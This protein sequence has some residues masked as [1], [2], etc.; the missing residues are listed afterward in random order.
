MAEDVRGALAEALEL[1]A[2]CDHAGAAALCKRASLMPS[3]DPRARCDALVAHARNVVRGSSPGSRGLAPALASLDSAAALASSATDRARVVAAKA[4][5]LALWAPRSFSADSSAAAISAERMCPALPEAL[6]ASGEAALASGDPSRAETQLARAVASAGA[7]ISGENL[8]EWLSALAIARAATGVVEP[9]RAC[10]DRASQ[11]LAGAS[12]ADPCVSRLH[13]VAVGAVRLASGDARAAL[14]ALQA[15]VTDAVEREAKSDAAR[16]GI[17]VAAAHALAGPVATGRR[18]LKAA[19]HLLGASGPDSDEDCVL[20][21]AARAAAKLQ[22]HDSALSLVSRALKAA[23]RTGGRARRACALAL[24]AQLLARLGR[25]EA[26]GKALALAA[27]ACEADARALSEAPADAAAAMYDCAKAALLLGDPARAIATASKC[28]SFA[29]D[30]RLVLLSCRAKILWGRAA[31]EMMRLEEAVQALESAL[32]EA[33]AAKLLPLEARALCWLSLARS[34]VGTEEP[35]D[36]WLTRALETAKARAGARY[37]LTSGGEQACSKRLEASVLAKMGA[38]SVSSGDLTSGL[39]SFRQAADRFAA[40][41]LPRSLARVRLRWAE[42]LA[43]LEQWDSAVQVATPATTDTDCDPILCALWRVIALCHSAAERT[44]ESSKALASAMHIARGMNDQSEGARCLA[45]LRSRRGQHD[46]ALATLDRALSACRKAKNRALQQSIVE[47]MSS[48]M[49][50]VEA[51]R[52]EAVAQELERGHL[53]ARDA[54]GALLVRAVLCQAVCAGDRQRALRMC[55]DCLCRFRDGMDDGVKADVLS[56]LGAVLLDCG[57]LATACDVFEEAAGIYESLGELRGSALCKAGRGRA[58]GAQG[59]EQAAVDALQ[60]AREDA[61]RSGSTRVILAVADALQSIAQAD[62]PTLFAECAVVA[63]RCGDAEAELRNLDSLGALLS[64]EEDGERAVQVHQRAAQ[65]AEALG[66][67][68]LLGHHSLLL[69]EALRHA[70]A[71]KD[72]V[73][74]YKRAVSS[75]RAVDMPQLVSLATYKLAKAYFTQGNGD[76]SMEICNGGLRVVPKGDALEAKYWMLLGRIMLARRNL[77]G[78]FGFLRK[79][80]AAAQASGSPTTESKCNLAVS[81]GKLL[82]GALAESLAHA[83]TALELSRADQ[84]H[85]LSAQVLAV[86]AGIRRMQEDHA[87]EALML[88]EAIEECRAAGDGGALE[89]DLLLALGAAHR[90]AGDWDKSLRAYTASVAI[91][92]ARDDPRLRLDA[93]RGQANVLERRGDIAEALQA[94]QEAVGYAQ[95]C[96]EASSEPAAHARWELAQTLSRAGRRAEAIRHLRQILQD[97]WWWHEAATHCALGKE[98]L[99]LGETH[100]SLRDYQ[101]ALTIYDRHEHKLGRG[102]VLSS[103]A[104]IYLVRGDEPSK[105][106]ATA[107]QCLA[108]AVGCGD[109][110]LE[111]AAMCTLGRAHLARGD[112]DVAGK[113]LVSAWRMCRDACDRPRLAWCTEYIGEVLA[114]RGCFADARQRFDE[115]AKLAAEAGMQR[116]VCQARHNLGC[117]LAQE[118]SYPEASAVLNEALEMAQ[119][120]CDRVTEAAILADMSAVLWATG[121]AGPAVDMQQRALQLVEQP[122]GDGS[123][124]APA[125]TCSVLASQVL[126][127]KGFALLATGDVQLGVETLRA[128]TEAAPTTGITEPAQLLEMYAALGLGCS[129]L[130]KR[131]QALRYYE[132]AEEIASSFPDATRAMQSVLNEAIGEEHALQGRAAQA[133]AR[134]NRA[135]ATAPDVPCR[136]KIFNSTAEAHIESGNFSACAEVAQSALTLAKAAGDPAVC[137]RSLINIGKAL[138]AQRKLRNALQKFAAAMRLSSENGLVF[139]DAYARFSVGETLCAAGE[140]GLAI[141]YL[142]ASVQASRDGGYVLVQ[143][144]ALSALGAAY[145][146]TQ[147]PA[148]AVECLQAALALLEKR[149]HSAEVRSRLRLAEALVLCG[150]C[151]RAE[152]VLASAVALAGSGPPSTAAGTAREAARISA[153][154]SRKRSAILADVHLLKK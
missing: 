5:L 61:R 74:A 148:R 97:T 12:R 17:A 114:F 27:A 3:R 80:L 30:S 13:R 6:A 118:G 115:A 96:G 8:A 67:T 152:S 4:S 24:H 21:T 90:D 112:A 87:I 149:H 100:L 19:A 133:L 70:G 68:E 143:G 45:T 69:A 141:E 98:H 63:R 10:L 39:D 109:A 44:E 26:A 85:R 111:R 28:S 123:G 47:Q 36:S 72:A 60:S 9:A 91:A 48:E 113:Y 35:D 128:A 153:M 121:E 151:D 18:A 101:A 7:E 43:S 92:Q 15:A 82:E 140:A 16:I 31:I 142:D 110:G 138:L 22:S 1:S 57:T 104:E 107:E 124:K 55:E 139:F 120:E 147:E 126:R 105:A 88:D 62:D 65:L 75:F 106:M 144:S 32:E 20:L 130:G 119:K 129:K 132:K 150:D 46:K 84:N 76:K 77:A 11:A 33:A 52:M 154:A 89:G 145:T 58:L 117:A 14:E 137:C 66:R 94:L 127:A 125:Y 136:A 49:P 116:L 71:A 102:L 51:A 56:V 95:D 2:R 29:S 50:K 86:V 25:A 79:A 54:D 59:H 131:V 78:A 23:E 42:T 83:V 135:V 122:A 53:A 64:R 41:G 34:L 93:L 146:A 37:T 81:H 134:F 103:L 73:R 99:L 38:C 108:I 40:V